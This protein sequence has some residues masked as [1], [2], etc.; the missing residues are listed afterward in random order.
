MCRRR[1]GFTLI[2][3]LVVFS[4]ISVLAGLVLG[5]LHVARERA[6]QAVCCSNLGQLG[7]AVSLYLDD[8]NLSLPMAMQQDETLGTVYFTD[9]LVVPYVVTGTPSMRTVTDQVVEGMRLRAAGKLNAIF[10]CPNAGDHSTPSYGVNAFDDKPVTGPNGQSGTHQFGLCWVTR[11]GGF[12]PISMNEITKSG[13]TIYLVDSRPGPDFWHVGQAAASA[14]SP[15][16]DFTTLDARHSNHYC[17]LYLDWHAQ[18]I[19]KE[20]PDDWGIMKPSL[21]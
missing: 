16:T 2:E 10:Y 4:I 19:Y 11:S 6:R 12:A 8:N 7:K 13:S 21:Q 5:A 17:A 1:S 20:D 15:T 3:I 18:A 9:L 14:Q